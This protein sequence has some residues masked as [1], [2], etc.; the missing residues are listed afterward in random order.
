MKRSTNVDLAENL[1]FRTCTSP[2]ALVRG[3]SI[4][5]EKIQILYVFEAANACNWVPMLFLLTIELEAN[6]GSKKKE[7]FK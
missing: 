4:I 5:T 6:E 7:N 3:N 2:V 1:S